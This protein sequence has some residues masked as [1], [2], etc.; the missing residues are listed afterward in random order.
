MTLF[1]WTSNFWWFLSHFGRSAIRMIHHHVLSFRPLCP[2]KTSHFERFLN[3]LQNGKG[4]FW[5]KYA[6][7]R[8]NNTYLQL[9]FSNGPRTLGDFSPTLRGPPS[10]WSTTM[11]SLLDPSVH[12]R[13][14]TLRGFWIFFKIAFFNWTSK[15]TMMFFWLKYA[16]FQTNNQNRQ[17]PF[18]NGPLTLGDWSPSLPSTFT[19]SRSDPPS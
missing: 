11:S 1:K 8:T 5:L 16:L 7:F 15:S 19:S 4:L 3:F 2:R 17:W 13:P 12:V 18:L 6:L 10:L 9:P 14:S